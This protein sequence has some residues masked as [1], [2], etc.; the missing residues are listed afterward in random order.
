M[1]GSEVLPCWAATEFNRG[2]VLGGMRRSVMDSDFA[3]RALGQAGEPDES[4]G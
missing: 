2:S 4:R 3:F 1:I